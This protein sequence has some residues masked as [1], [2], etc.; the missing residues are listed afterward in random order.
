MS[1]NQEQTINVAIYF[2]LTSVKK[3]QKTLSLGLPHEN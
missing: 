2:P 1:P 3:S